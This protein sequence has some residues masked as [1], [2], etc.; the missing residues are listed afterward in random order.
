[1]I[2]LIVGAPLIGYIPLGG[3]AIE[4]EPPP[5]KSI[6]VMMEWVFSLFIR[7]IVRLLLA[8]CVL[9]VTCTKATEI[10]GN[11]N[12]CYGLGEGTERSIHTTL[13]EYGKA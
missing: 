1:M 4:Q 2:L 9:L 8:K 6:Q 3:V 10:F 5:W 11:P 7:K 12:L 13:A